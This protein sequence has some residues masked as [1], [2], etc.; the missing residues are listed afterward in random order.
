MH[1][2]SLR[3][4]R[5]R[6]SVA[7]S[8]AIRLAAHTPPGPC[9]N[10]ALPGA[11]CGRQQRALRPALPLRRWALRAQAIYFKLYQYYVRGG[12]GGV[13]CCKPQCARVVPGLG[14]TGMA[15]HGAPSPNAT[16]SCASQAL[17][18]ATD[19]RPEDQ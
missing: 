16:P 14:M 7:Q 19:V 6:E 15:V 2:C 4:L 18:A 13:P 9:C 1:V 8:G 12:M 17:L 3:H 10:Q 5:P 11:A